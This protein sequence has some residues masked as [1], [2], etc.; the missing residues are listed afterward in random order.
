M[1]NKKS[2]VK[3]S[4]A[5]KFVTMLI[6]SVMAVGFM[7]V[8]FSFR[9]F[10]TYAS[11]LAK[12]NMLDLAQTYGIILDDE[13]ESQPQL[14]DYYT[15]MKDLLENAHIKG[16]DSSYAYLVS[17]TG[18]MIY[19]PT[20]EKVGQPVENVVVKDVIARIEAGEEVESAV[21]EY[22]FKG[23]AKYAGYYV[24]DS[25]SYVLVISADKSE[26]FEPINELLSKIVIG[27]LIMLAMAISISTAICIMMLKSLK[28]TSHNISLLSEGYTDLEF[29]SGKINHGDEIFKVADS[30]NYFTKKLKSI[31]ITVKDNANM[32]RSITD[33]VNDH[34]NTADSISSGVDQ[35]VSDIANGAQDMASSIETMAGEMNDIGDAI[36]KVREETTTCFTL[37]GEVEKAV[38]AS[39]ETLNTLISDNKASASNAENITNGIQKIIDVSKDIQSVTDLIEEI[40]TQT[41]LLALNASIEAAHAGEAGKGFAVVAGEIKKLAAQSAEHVVTITGIVNNIIDAAKEN[42]KY[43]EEIGSSISAEQSTL[44]A[45]VNSFMF[46][47]QKLE[48]AMSSVHVCTE[49][50][51]DLDQHKEEVLDAITNLSAISEENASSTQET[52]ASI[53]TLRNDI[54]GISEEMK[55]LTD[56]SE[57]LEETLSFFKD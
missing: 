16:L 43:A 27:A 49:A 6:L 8:T 37:S 46:M 1:S 47:H 25:E 32:C 18:R 10:K 5:T 51:K 39:Q 17:P 2:I 20:Q 13:L 4:V 14:L 12:N 29:T 23:E 33:S 57:A 50:T 21:T 56:A 44:D 28:T 53:A 34:V 55:K 48:A 35:A 36:S 41:N 3:T 40:A 22:M 38:E 54:E 31:L 30:M 11:D 52:A 42:S 9:S 19:H 45:V 7:I 15:E 26:I 24:P